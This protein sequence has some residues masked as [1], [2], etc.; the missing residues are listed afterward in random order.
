MMYENVILE[1]TEACKALLGNKLVG[2]YLHGSAAMGCFNPEKSDIDFIVIINSDMTRDEKTDFIRKTV[3]L[4][5]KAPEK[6]IE[7][8]I[9]KREF[10]DPFV[11][12]T[13]YEL[14]FSSAHLGLWESSEDEYIKTLTGEDYDLAAHFTVINTYGR[15]LYGESVEKVFGEVPREDYTD[16]ILYDVENAREDIFRDP[17][18]TILNLCRV[19]AYLKDD[20]ILS[21][22]AG[23]KWALKTLPKKYYSLIQCAL[24]CYTSSSDAEISTSDAFEFA[25]F[26][27]YDIEK[28]IAKTV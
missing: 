11:Y 2:V 19:S 28:E 1:F 14:H 17:I 22:K 6:G 21:K 13:P 26:M 8:S 9:V 24:D 3:E 12:P 15:V 10:C 18:Y 16:S 7:M 27:L 5:R 4:N 23:G 25:D 20:L